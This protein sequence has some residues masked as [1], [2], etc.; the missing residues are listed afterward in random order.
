[1]PS[2]W[3]SESREAVEQDL[4]EALLQAQSEYEQAAQS[5]REDAKKRWRAALSEFSAMVFGGKRRFTRR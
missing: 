4:R 3:S 1:M 5:A 2:G